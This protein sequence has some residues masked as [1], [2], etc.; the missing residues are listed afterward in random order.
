[1]A[2]FTDKET[3]VWGFR[4]CPWPHRVEIPTCFANC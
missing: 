4:T 1:M 3:K 2:H